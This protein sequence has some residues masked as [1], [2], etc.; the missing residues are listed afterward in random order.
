MF[1]VHRKSENKPNIEFREHESDLHIYDP[2]KNEELTFVGTVSESK[3]G[4]T[5]RQI[6]GE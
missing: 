2:R 3:E 6:K 5:K 1:V 4:F